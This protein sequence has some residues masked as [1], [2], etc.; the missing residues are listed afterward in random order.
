MK[1]A[2]DRFGQKPLMQGFIG[3]A[4]LHIPL[5]LSAV[6]AG[7]FGTFSWKGQTFKTKA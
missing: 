6:L 2:T 5:I 3:A 7:T 1:D 4:L